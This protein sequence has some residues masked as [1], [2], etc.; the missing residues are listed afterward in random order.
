M[1]LKIVSESTVTKQELA[2]Q[3]FFEGGCRPTSEKISLFFIADERDSSSCLPAWLSNQMF[4]FAG[5][6]TS[7]LKM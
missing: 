5:M 3:D 2:A 6:R 1:F 7:F 4:L